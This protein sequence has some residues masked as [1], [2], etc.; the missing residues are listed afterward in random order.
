MSMQAETV[1]FP[2]SFDPYTIGHSDLVRRGLQI[3]G[4]IVIA[5]GYN[6]HKKGLIPI[7]E[8][9]DALRSLYA[10]EP[11]VT[12]E[13][14][15]CLTTDFAKACGASVILRGVR[16]EKDYAYERELADVNRQLAGVE[17]LLLFASPQ[18]GSVSSSTVRELVHFGKDVSAFLPQGLHYSSI[19]QEKT[20]R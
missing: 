3:F 5:I 13:S 10:S 9:V 11:R 20:D 6:E 19:N 16:S 17:T 18:Y 1:L 15:S 7:Q 8:R 14:Y 4:R 12:V 2:G